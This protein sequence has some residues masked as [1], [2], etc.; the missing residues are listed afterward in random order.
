MSYKLLDLSDVL[1][2]IPY[3]NTLSKLHAFSDL[4]KV[5]YPRNALRLLDNLMYLWNSFYRS[6]TIDF[7]GIW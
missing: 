3:D 1:S 4:V 2:S 7:S 5:A 6:P